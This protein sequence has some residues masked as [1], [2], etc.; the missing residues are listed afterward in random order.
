MFAFVF[1]NT[2]NIIELFDIK[3]FEKSDYDICGSDFFTEV[4]SYT[5][6]ALIFIRNHR[7]S[8]KGVPWTKSEPQKFSKSTKINIFSTQFYHISFHCMD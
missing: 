2:G 7:R 6:P 3:W 5:S 1:G 4:K 8:S